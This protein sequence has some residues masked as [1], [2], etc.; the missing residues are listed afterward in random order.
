MTANEYRFLSGVAIIF[1]TDC[2]M[3]TQLYEYT[4]KTTLY[5]TLSMSK[6]YL[7]EAVIF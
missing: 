6:L 5:C 3:A 4:K 2:G 1:K 7:N